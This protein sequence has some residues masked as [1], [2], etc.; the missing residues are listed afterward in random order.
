MIAIGIACIVTAIGYNNWIYDFYVRL[1]GYW[2]EGD[3]I[4]FED[5]LRQ[6]RSRIED[7]TA[8]M[9]ELIGSGKGVPMPKTLHNDLSEYELSFIVI[10]DGAGRITSGMSRIL[11]RSLDSKQIL[12]RPD[13]EQI[14]EPRWVPAEFA[15]PEHRLQYHDTLPLIGESLAEFGIVRDSLRLGRTFS[16]I[17]RVSPSILMRLGLKGQGGVHNLA[18][19]SSREIPGGL[20][21]SGM[22]LNGD[23]TLV[24]RMLITHAAEDEVTIYAD[25]IAIATN[26]HKEDRIDRLYG[27]TMPEAIAERVLKNGQT[28]WG[29]VVLGDAPHYVSANPLWD[30]SIQ[31]RKVSHFI[32]PDIFPVGILS[33][34]IHESFFRLDRFWYGAVAVAGSIF[35]IALTIIGLF[36]ARQRDYEKKAIIAEEE[37]ERF[38][39]VAQDQRIA[40]IVAQRKNEFASMVHDTVG[41][42]I[43]LSKTY[44]Y[45]VRDAIEQDLPDTEEAS[46]ALE[47]LQEALQQ[48]LQEIRRSALSIDPRLANVNLE[49]GL[50][51]LVEE[52]EKAKNQLI[53]S[54]NGKGPE[55]PT[56][57]RRNVYFIAQEAVRNAF[58]NGKARTV[59]LELFRSVNAVRVCVQDDG[60]GF[61]TKLV[62]SADHGGK[63]LVIMHERAKA[64]SGNLKIESVEGQ[65]TRV[66]LEVPI[67]N[68][69]FRQ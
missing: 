22:L 3:R 16:G 21:I 33:L 27:V 49:E 55:L 7:H 32:S 52:W 45:I 42:Y 29:L 19:V 36:Y 51:G 69:D 65:G 9:R 46:L 14:V 60:L 44:G 57:A 63:G 41:Q 31:I 12:M 37:A 18:I 68:G 6:K 30:H 53:L 26:L 43:A 1:T 47:N 11:D 64:I 40:V 2:F 38:R 15:V 62:L 20:A 66:E 48:G 67:I 39:Q 58:V 59:H 25:N 13:Q 61:D 50:R 17:E 54:V 56:E 24:D 4:A 28:Y 10:T 23:P 35:I 34:S 5:I 8:L